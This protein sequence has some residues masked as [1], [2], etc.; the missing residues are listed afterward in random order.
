MNANPPAVKAINTIVVFAGAALLAV[1]A[2]LFV[3]GRPHKATTATSPAVSSTAPGSPSV[4]ATA[5]PAV[6]GPL[7]VNIADFAFSPNPAVIAVGS[8]ITWTNKDSFAHT[9]KFAASNGAAAEESPSLG[10][11]AN[12]SK[13]FATPGT[14]AYICGIHNS[15]TG[16]VTVK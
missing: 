3:Q 13:T 16:T 6:A 10:S 1:A 12:F 8:T 2:I 5:G 7:A 14:Y 11:G 15:M 4:D 9:V